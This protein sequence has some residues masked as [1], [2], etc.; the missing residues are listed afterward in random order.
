MLDARY[1]MSVI[2]YPV[3]SIQYPVSSMRNIKLV[4]E[5]DGTNYRGWQLQPGLKTIQGILE[6]GLSTITKG[7]VTLYGAGRTDAGVHALGQVANFRT[8]SRMTP[9]E[10]R[11]ALN[12]VLPGD[13]VI[14]HV[15]EV[16]EDF[17]ARYS[18]VSRTYRYTILSEKTP[19]AFLRNYVYQV[20]YS[21]DVDSMADS[22]KL[23]LGTH[24]FSSF[25]S[26]GDPVRDFTRTVTYAGIQQQVSSIEHPASSIEHLVSS[27]QYRLIHFQIE[28]NAFLRCMVRAIAGTLLEIGKGKMHPEKMRDIMEARDRRAA[29]PNLPGKGLYLVKVDYPQQGGE[30]LELS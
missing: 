6:S 10:F 2:Q 13:I 1:S 24:D 8:D 17:H 29:G 25:A 4:I 26:T 28:A 12:S 3:S 21:I 9:E 22:C 7:D 14:K 27:I 20:P 30:I 23:L 18:A 16:E 11:M 19:S 15:Q 5:Y